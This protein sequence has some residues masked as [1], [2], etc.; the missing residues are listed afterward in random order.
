MLHSNSSTSPAQ[1]IEPMASG[2]RAL[3]AGVGHALHQARDEYI[4]DVAGDLHSAAKAFR[5]DGLASGLAGT[6]DALDPIRQ[7]AHALDAVGILPDGPV[8]KNIFTAAARLSVGGPLA[9]LLAMKDAFDIHRSMPYQVPPSQWV[10]SP[11]EQYTNTCQGRV[12]CPDGYTPSCLVNDFQSY[13]AGFLTGQAACMLTALGPG[14]SFSGPGSKEQHCWSSVDAL[15]GGGCFEDYVAAF[16]VDVIKHEQRLANRKMAELKSLNRQKKQVNG[17]KAM[18]KIASQL[19]KTVGSAVGT[20]AG[21]MLGMGFG[22]MIG[23]QCGKLLVNASTSKS[24][25]PAD[26]LKSAKDRGSELE[27]S[28]VLKMEE[29]KNIMNRLQQMLQALS[30]VLKVMHDGAMSSIRNIR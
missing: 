17:Q 2:V 15:D 13:F 21:G 9:T 26:L 19:G 30:A 7:V 8:A 5:K 4:Q 22:S 11:S 16:M 29:L 3:R 10:P 18:E 25:N 24:K 12:R 6:L 27:D 23:E 20:G 28:R 14:C 1:S